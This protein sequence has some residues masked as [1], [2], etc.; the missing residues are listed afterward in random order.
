MF[1]CLYNLLGQALFALKQLKSS[2]NIV[3]YVVT[4]AGNDFNADPPSFQSLTCGNK[5]YIHY[6][7]LFFNPNYY[8]VAA[9]R[10]IS[11]GIPP[12]G[13]P[14]IT[15]LPPPF[16]SALTDVVG[17]IPPRG[18]VSDPAV[19]SNVKGTLPSNATTLASF[20]RAN[21]SQVMHLF[22]QFSIIRQCIGNAQLLG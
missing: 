7:N 16:Q 21:A 2:V 5:T 17:L 10:V 18:M 14:I 15:I 3:A 9:A 6:V 12:K 4:G 11:D 8:A 19:Y 20:S 1:D 13:N 22:S